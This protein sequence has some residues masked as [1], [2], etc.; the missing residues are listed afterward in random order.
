[1]GNAYGIEEASEQLQEA[2]IT[3]YHTSCPDRIR[4]FVVSNFCPKAGCNERDFS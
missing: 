2:I 1:M 4:V 3:S